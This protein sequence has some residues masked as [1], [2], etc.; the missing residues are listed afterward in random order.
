MAATNIRNKQHK[1]SDCEACTQKK[2]YCRGIISLSHVSNI[3]AYSTKIQKLVTNLSQIHNKKWLLLIN[4]LEYVHKQ[5][6]AVSTGKNWIHCTFHFQ[7]KNKIATGVRLFQSRIR[8]LKKGT[9][10]NITN[11]KH[12]VL[13][14]RKKFTTKFELWLFE[15]ILC[16]Y[17]KKLV[18]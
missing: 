3:K 15:N 1:K 4:T 13:F 8:V 9:E 11:N 5:V 14:S 16:A 7:R 2:A 10:N 12:G 18:K 17:F 6:L